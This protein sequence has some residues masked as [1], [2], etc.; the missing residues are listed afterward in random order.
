MEDSLKIMEAYRVFLI[1]VFDDITR[2]HLC[3]QAIQNQVLALYGGEA[4]FHTHIKAHPNKFF[5]ALNDKVQMSCH[6][7]FLL[8]KRY[9]NDYTKSYAK[10]WDKIYSEID[11][12]V[13]SYLD[14]C[15]KAGNIIS[16]ADGSVSFELLK[17][18]AEERNA[19]TSEQMRLLAAGGDHPWQQPEFIKAHS[20]HTSEQMR[21]LVARKNH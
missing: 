19:C 11:F 16:E 7:E 20:K 12:L 15:T 3:F 6:P 9:Q 2:I 10:L 5:S 17:R 14:K 21:D 8:N 1:T 4:L 18:A 13:I